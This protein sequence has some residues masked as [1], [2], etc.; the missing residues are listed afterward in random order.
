MI[1]NIYILLMITCQNVETFLGIFGAFLGRNLLD[2]Y[3]CMF[4]PFW[5]S[6]FAHFLKNIFPKMPQKMR[7]T[8][9]KNVQ[10]IP[11]KNAKTPHQMSNKMRKRCLK[12]C[13]KNAQKMP[14]KVSKFWH[15]PVVR[16]RKEKLFCHA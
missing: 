9:L 13:P 3:W 1:N 11:P 8:C 16:N 10:K 12:K 2:I 5:D 14:R 7:K 4:R 15:V 6:F